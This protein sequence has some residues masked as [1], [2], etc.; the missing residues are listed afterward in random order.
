MISVNTNISVQI[1]FCL[2]KDPIPRRTMSLERI[3]EM[4]PV[5]L[6]DFNHAVFASVEQPEGLPCVLSQGE[7]VSV[8]ILWGGY[9][10][11]WLDTV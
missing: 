6:L 1:G 7:G 2:R 9:M 11:I 10:I 5:C 3:V 8:P 4:A